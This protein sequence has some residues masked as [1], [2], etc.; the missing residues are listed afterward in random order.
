[1]SDPSSAET[2]PRDICVVGAGHWGRNLVRNF[3]A[4]GVL[5]TVCDANEDTLARGLEM[6]P[7]AVGARNLSEVLQDPRVQG[8]VIASP[9]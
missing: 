6:A 2:F 9:A 1:M 8:V 3:H 7:G 5:R 4:L